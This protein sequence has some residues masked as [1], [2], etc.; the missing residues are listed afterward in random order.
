MAITA[1]SVMTGDGTRQ[2]ESWESGEF[3][4]SAIEATI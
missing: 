4:K 2:V 3:L 1:E